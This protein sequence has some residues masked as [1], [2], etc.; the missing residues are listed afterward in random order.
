[1]ELAGGPQILPLLFRLALG[2]DMAAEPAVARVAAGSWPR[3][4]YFAW[5]QTPMA[6]TRLSGIEGLDDVAALPHVAT[7]MRNQR[8]GDA[9]DWARGGRF[10]VSEVFGSVDVIG[11]L[12]AARDEIDTTITLEFEEAGLPRTRRRPPRR[13]RPHRPRRLPARQRSM[14]MGLE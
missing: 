11:E 12:A 5:I 2:Q 8:Q 14:T 9:L 10:N 4:G 7:V 3:V 13:E 1:M 6:A